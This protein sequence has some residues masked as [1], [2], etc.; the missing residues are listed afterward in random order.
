MP[1]EL[2][3]RFTEEDI[4]NVQTLMVRAFRLNKEPYAYPKE[5]RAE[6]IEQLRYYAFDGNIAE[7]IIKNLETV[8]KENHEKEYSFSEMG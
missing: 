4:N 7:R 3:K 1:E 5:F 8:Y 2:E 6:V